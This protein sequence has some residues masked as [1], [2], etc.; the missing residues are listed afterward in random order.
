MLW[1][2]LDEFSYWR[3]IL[4]VFFGQGILGVLLFEWAWKQVERVRLAEEEMMKEFPSFRRLDAHMWSRKTFYPGCFLMLVPRTIVIFGSVFLV[5]GCQRLLFAGQDMSVPLAG[6]RRDL[7]KRLL[8]CVVPLTIFAFG[9]TL[10]L[11]DHDEIEVDYSKYLGPNWRENKFQGKRVSTIVSNHIGFIEIL[12]YIALMTPPSF[13]PA[14]QVKDF[15][16]GDHFVRCLNSI[17]VDRTQKKEKRDALVRELGRRQRIIETDDRDWGPICFFAEGSVTNG[18]NISRFRRGG[19]ESGVAVQPIFFRNLYQSVSPDYA[20]V[21]G[22]ELGFLMLSEFAIN[23]FDAH[24]YPIFVPNDYL[25]TEYAKTI[26][27]FSD[28]PEKSMEKW[29]IY[30][31]AVEDLMRREGGFG[32]SDQAL[33]EKVSLQKFLWGERDEISVN[34]KTFFWPPKSGSKHVLV[35]EC[36]ASEKKTS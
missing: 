12:A 14:R 16:I 22:L 2:L 3:F 26:P 6:W 18:K 29:E 21:K 13:T 4:V 32:V 23:I 31:H 24:R 1:S 7:H 10:M 8:W 5:G 27:G 30:A 15:P 28:G 11:T 35:S 34:G 36:S 19:F 25:Y 17:Y 9:Y 20:I 33:R